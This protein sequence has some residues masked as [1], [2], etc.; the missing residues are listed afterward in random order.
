MQQC[1]VLLRIPSGLQ[2]YAWSGAVSKKGKYAASYPRAVAAYFLWWINHQS[3]V[4]KSSEGQ[5]SALYCFAYR[6]PQGCI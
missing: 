4:G 3:D 6:P 1:P 2:G 5:N